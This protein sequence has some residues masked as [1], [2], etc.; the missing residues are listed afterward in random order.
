MEF[1]DIV[2]IQYLQHN[3]SFLGVFV[4]AL[5]HEYQCVHKLLNR[6][7]NMVFD[8]VVFK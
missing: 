4:E 5:Y 2:V 3:G 6:D 1:K 8:F 7:Y